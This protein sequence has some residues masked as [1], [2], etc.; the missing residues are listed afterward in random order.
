MAYGIASLVFLVVAI[1]LGFRAES[2]GVS[3]QIRE[4]QQNLGTTNYPVSKAQLEF[5]ASA[6]QTR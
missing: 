4:A 5:G 2:L 6:G 1:T 3:R